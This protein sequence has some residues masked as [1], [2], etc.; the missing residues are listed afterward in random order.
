MS[1]PRAWPSSHSI[2]FMTYDTVTRWGTGP[3][4]VERDE[5]AQP[6]VPPVAR[7]MRSVSRSMSSSVP[8]ALPNWCW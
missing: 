6:A 5:R 8:P 2:W 4:R 7:R 3:G 1:R